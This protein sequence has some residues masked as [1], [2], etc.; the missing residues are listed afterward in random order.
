MEIAYLHDSVLTESDLL[1]FIEKVGPDFYPNLS[2]RVDLTA[3]TEKL[4]KQAVI[5]IILDKVRNKIW[6]M[7]AFYCTPKSYED[8]FLSFI[9]IDRTIRSK[10]LGF[11]LINQMIQHVREAGMSAI[12][13]RTWSGNTHMIRLIEGVGFKLTQKAIDSNGRL[14]MHYRLELDHSLVGSQNNVRN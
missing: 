12:E 4:Y 5:L 9:A 2:T 1:K 14:S 8:A 7:L 11:A 10:R 13:T 3:Y 6:G